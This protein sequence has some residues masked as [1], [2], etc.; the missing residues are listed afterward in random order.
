[1]LALPALVAVAAAAA[2][3]VTTG[4]AA[5]NVRFRDVR[6]VVPFMVQLWL[7][8][9]PVVYPS[10]L[11][12]EPWQ[13]L[14]AINPMTGVVEGFRWAVLDAGPAPVD[15]MLISAG[16]AVLFF[17]AGLAYFARVERDFADVI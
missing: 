9:T 16:S 1:M 6:Y 2:M 5:L 3:G 12:D 4:L 10:S 14:S 8:L 17:L 7:F 13:T 15:L 11:L